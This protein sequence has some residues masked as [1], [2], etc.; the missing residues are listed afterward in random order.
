MNKREKKIAMAEAIIRNAKA[1]CEFAKEHTPEELAMFVFIV[2][3]TLQVEL[4]TIATQIDTSKYARGGV[5]RLPER[6]VGE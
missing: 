5:V 3:H 1:V 2:G 4:D 6:K